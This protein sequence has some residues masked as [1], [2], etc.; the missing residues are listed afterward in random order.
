MT[1]I[2]LTELEVAG[3]AGLA[4]RSL[5]AESGEVNALGIP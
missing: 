2:S 5:P 3:P 4:L 1:S